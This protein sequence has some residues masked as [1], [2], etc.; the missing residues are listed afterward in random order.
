MMNNPL[1]SIH[2]PGHL[3]R[4]KWSYM[5]QGLYLPLRF[6]FSSK[7]TW[8]FNLN[9]IGPEIRFNSPT[10]FFPRSNFERWGNMN[11][12]PFVRVVLNFVERW[13]S[14][15]TAPFV[16]HGFTRHEARIFESELKKKKLRYMNIIR[17]TYPAWK[18][19]NDMGQ[20]EVERHKPVSFQACIKSDAG[21][22]NLIEKLKEQSAL[23]VQL[24][25]IELRICVYMSGWINTS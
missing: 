12:K 21:G 5:G 4:E 14:K 6:F 22:T 23:K 17:P 16:Y 24:N 20:Y 7:G 15:M 9:V 18:L 1:T 25:L 10:H 3:H 13:K 11:S 19:V 8:I 2:L